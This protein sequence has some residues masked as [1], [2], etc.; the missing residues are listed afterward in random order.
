[1]AVQRIALRGPEVRPP[2]PLDA[3]GDGGTHRGE[4]QDEGNG[5]HGP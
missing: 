2:W 3:P 1:V 5:A 4:H